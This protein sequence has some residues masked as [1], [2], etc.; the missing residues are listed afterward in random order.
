MGVSVGS[1]DQSCIIIHKMKFL[2]VAV[3]LVAAVSADADADAF[4]GY[5]G[6]PYAYGV[7]AFAGKSAPCVNAANVPV[8]CAGAHMPTLATHMLTTMARERPRLMLKLTQ[9]SSMEL[10]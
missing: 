5:Y 3:A 9:P 1:K 7:H 4:Y 8:P 6:Y 2:A 10:M